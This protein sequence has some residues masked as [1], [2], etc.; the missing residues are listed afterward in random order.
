MSRKILFITLLFCLI[1]WGYL[2]SQVPGQMSYQ[3][4]LTG[5]EGEPVEDGMYEMH[6]KL[7]N[8]IDPTAELW[9][10]TQTISIINGLFN[11]ILGTE[12]PLELPFDEQYYLGIAVGDGAELTPRIALTSS[13]Y[14]YRAGSIDDG[15]VVKSINELKDDIIL[16]AGDNVSITGDENKIIISAESTGGS[17]NIT[18]ITA[19]EGLIGGGSEGE[20]TLAVEDEGITSDKLAS[21]VVTSSKL[22]DEAV[23]QEKLHPHVSVP[24]S[25]NAG[26]D[27]TGT[28]PDPEI[29]E[30]VV[31]TSKLADGSVTGATIANGAAVRSIN[32]LTDDV[33]LT[34]KGGV[35]IDFGDD[36]SIV[37]DAGSVVAKLPEP[38]Y[39][40]KDNNNVGIGTDKPS[41]P[42]TVEGIVEST[43][44]FQLPD[45]TI[46]EDRSD[47]A[48]DQSLSGA[49]V[50]DERGN[51]GIGTST[52]G[53][54][55][56]VRDANHQ[57]EIIDSD[58]EK[59]WTIT[60]IG[61][62]D[63]GF[64]E[65]GSTSRMMIETG[66]KVGIGTNSPSDRLHVDAPAGENALRVRVGGGTRLRVHDNGGV[67]VGVN[68]QP[69]SRGLLV[70]GDIELNQAQTRWYSV[71]GGDFAWTGH[72]QGLIPG[73][74]TIIL[75][76]A[77]SCKGS[78]RCFPSVSINLPHGAT[79]TELSAGVRDEM[80]ADF[81]RVTLR[82]SPHS[83]GD[84]FTLAVA[85]SEGVIGSGLTISDD[86][87]N[88]SVI[89][90][91]KYVYWL[92][93]RI[94]SGPG[95]SL[96]AVR[97]TYTVTS[98]LP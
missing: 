14:S 37:I 83:T 68:A 41:S 70:R 7:Y 71:I 34:A 17:S 12:T 65:N 64:Y 19:G 22:A 33:T 86:Q 9:S 46:L 31:T 44:G 80:A 1:S 81:V 16:E 61:D 2:L 63:L 94:P 78:V 84:S 52:P 85:T 15:Q 48:G 89:D 95:Y 93:L 47:L 36:N 11:A 13:A 87:I 39:I 20:V 42:L 57:L 53:R 60:T 28:Y 62:Q 29:G 50:A 98:P 21:G 97:I 32:G 79:V 3:G 35:N 69:P 45:G 56:S 59:N 55:L 25:G 51:V 54:R 66:G 91:E 67:S 82:A 43:G 23:T 8:G 90:N 26:G 73:S 38:L 74:Q 24:I 40:D 75:N 4:M 27:L 49:I 10:E 18:Q 76:G 96:S 5:S 30:G 77:V 6:F 58:N 88:N 72:D 92:Q